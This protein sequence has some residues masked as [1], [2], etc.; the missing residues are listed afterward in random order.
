MPIDDT[1]R[2]ARAIARRLSRER[3]DVVPDRASRALRGGKVFVDWS[4]NDRMKSTVASP[5]EALER[6]ARHGDLF[7]PL[8]DRTGPLF[9]GSHVTALAY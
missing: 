6:L 9:H 1:K 2:F 8:L 4:Q 5:E 3:P 7:A